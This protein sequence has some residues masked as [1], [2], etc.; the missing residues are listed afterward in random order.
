MSSFGQGGSRDR[1]EGVPVHPDTRSQFGLRREQVA[2]MTAEGEPLSEVEA[3]LDSTK[4]PTDER[5]ALWL[6]AWSLHQRLHDEAEPAV[7][8]RFTPSRPHLRGLK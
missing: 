5:D 2:M 1:E 3:M 7:A 8:S 4:L 6:L